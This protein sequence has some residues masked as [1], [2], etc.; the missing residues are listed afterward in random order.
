MSGFTFRVRILEG[1]NS[2]YHEETGDLYDK[3]DEYTH[4]HVHTHNEAHI[5][6]G[7]NKDAMQFFFPSVLVVALSMIRALL[8]C[9]I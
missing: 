9:C 6:E 3:I 8:F 7:S 1:T 5:L 2:R 4:M